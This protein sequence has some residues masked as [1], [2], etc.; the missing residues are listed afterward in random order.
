MQ[1]A[2][3]T[4]SQVRKSMVE[5]PTSTPKKEVA[6]DAGAK[7]VDYRKPLKVYSDRHFKAK[8]IRHCVHTCCK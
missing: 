6:A 3:R 4:R 7:E 5:A 2:M 8:P 1:G